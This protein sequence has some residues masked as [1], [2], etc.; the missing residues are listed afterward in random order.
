MI[1]GYISNMIFFN[2]LLSSRVN[3]GKHVETIYILLENFQI[4]EKLKPYKLI[5][6][7]YS[8]TIRPLPSYFERNNMSFT[9]SYMYY[10]I[11]EFVIISSIKEDEDDY[12]K[13]LIFSMLFLLKQV[14]RLIHEYVVY[15]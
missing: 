10:L 6:D 2:V 14:S 1:I 12:S 13:I 3:N 7:L 11:K 15:T 9:N 5:T 4:T 8:H